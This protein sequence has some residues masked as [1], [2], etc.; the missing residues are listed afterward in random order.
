MS[1]LT[2]N[3]LARVEAKVD[4]LAVQV[5]ELVAAWNTARGVVKFVRYL[6]ATVVTVSAAVGAVWGLFHLGGQK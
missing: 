6:S 5:A 1:D 3:D 4:A 2:P